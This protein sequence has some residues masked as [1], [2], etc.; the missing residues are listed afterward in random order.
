MEKSD[1]LLNPEVMSYA[2]IQVGNIISRTF[3]KMCASTSVA[4]PDPGSGAFLTLD[5][6]SGI[7]L[8]RIPDL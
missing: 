1:D 6:G 7:D 2:E 3:I 4:D 8:F 5:Q